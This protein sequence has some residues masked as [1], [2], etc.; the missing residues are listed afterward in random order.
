MIENLAE[1]RRLMNIGALNGRTVDWRN[2]YPFLFGRLEIPAGKTLDVGSYDERYSKWLASQNIQ[3][4]VVSIDI[5]DLKEM[6]G[7]FVRA[8]ATSLPFKENAFKNSISIAAFPFIVDPI[9]ALHE[10][11]RVTSKSI[12]VWPAP[13]GLNVSAL[14]EKFSL[15]LFN[16]RLDDLDGQFGYLLTNALPRRTKKMHFLSGVFGG[17]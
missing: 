13:E 14:G 17:R 1:T 4:D 15:G 16:P 12:V 10:M 2:L 11:I 9:A 8:T 6:S 3:P 5:R 7:R